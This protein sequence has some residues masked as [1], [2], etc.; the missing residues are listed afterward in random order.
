MPR[1]SSGPCRGLAFVDWLLPPSAPGSVQLR[2]AP[3]VSCAASRLRKGSWAACW[4]NIASPSL[5]PGSVERPPH[6]VREHL[7]EVRLLRL[8]PRELPRR[9]RGYELL[10]SYSC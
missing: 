4:A 9:F 5:P 3:S 6:A 10:L 2:C 8:L 1:L 7:S